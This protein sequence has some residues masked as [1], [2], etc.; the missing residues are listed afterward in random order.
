MSVCVCLCLY[1]LRV[2]VFA[3]AG[4]CV[5]EERRMCLY[6]SALLKCLA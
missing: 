4:V 3:Y 1:S 5:Q 6:P 2:F